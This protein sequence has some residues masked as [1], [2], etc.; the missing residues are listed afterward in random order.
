MQIRDTTRIHIIF[1]IPLRSDKYHFSEAS[2][3]RRLYFLSASEKPTK[4]VIYDAQGREVTGVGGPFLEGYDL[5]LTCQVSGGKLISSDQKN[6]INIHPTW[7]KL[8]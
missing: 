8:N 3:N 2:L 7:N 4:P 6:N 1:H 5:L